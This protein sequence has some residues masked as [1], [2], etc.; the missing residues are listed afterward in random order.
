MWWVI[1]ETDVEGSIRR[2]CIDW[3]ARTKPGY[4]K[5]QFEESKMLIKPT[6]RRKQARKRGLVLGECQQD[7]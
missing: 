7:R 6:V 3:R 4:E 1:V 5:P 2:L